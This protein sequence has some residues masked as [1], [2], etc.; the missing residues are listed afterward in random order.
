[1]RELR[2]LAGLGVVVALLVGGCAG[3][4][5]GYTQPVSIY[6][7][8]DSTSLVYTNPRA[9]SQVYDHPLRWIA[10]MMNPLGVA[11]DYGVN[12]PIYTLS[13]LAPGIFGYTSED[14]MLDSQRW[15]LLSP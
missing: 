8:M 15:S 7:T 1:M 3:S 13:S 11:V 12:R 6:S 2:I 10:F 5:L 9:A 14:A 4:Q